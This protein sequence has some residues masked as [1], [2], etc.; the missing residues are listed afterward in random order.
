MSEQMQ[1]TPEQRIAIDAPEGPV[2]VIAG[3]GSGKTAVMA[4]RIATLIEHGR[5]PDEIVGLTFSNKAAENLRRRVADE[6][7]GG[8]D[9]LVTTYH[10]FG[11]SIVSEFAEDLGF[12][13]VPRLI[14]RASAFQLLYGAL[15]HVVFERR[16]IGRVAHLAAAALRLASQCSD[17]LVPVSRVI[18]DCDSMVDDIE[19]LEQVRNAARG[20]RDLARLVEIYRQVKTDRGFIDFGDQIALAVEALR[21]NGLRANAMRERH[22]VVLLD[23]YQDT[24]FAQRRLLQLIYPPGSPITVVG[25]DMQAIYAFRGSHLRNLFDFASHF[26]TDAHEGKPGAV[27]EAALTTNF[28]SGPQIVAVA[29]AVHATVGTAKDKAL[30]ARENA[31]A[32]VVEA[33]LCADELAEATRVASWISDRGAPWDE[34]IVLGRK[35]KIFPLIADALAARGIPVEILGIGGL[36][37]RPE[38]VDLLAWLEVLALE[39]ANVASLR[40]LRSPLRNI[41]MH[42]LAALAAHA[43][44]LARLRAPDDAHPNVQL[45][46]ALESVDSVPGLSAEA[47]QRVKTLLADRAALTHRLDDLRLPDL[48]EAIIQVERLRDRVDAVGTENLLRFLDVAERFVPLDGAATV[49]SFLDYLHLVMDGE[50]E[51]AEAVASATAAVRIMTIHQAKGLEFDNVVIAGLAGSKKSS[52]IFPD[53][54][55]SE[56]GATQMEVLPLWLRE[57]NDGITGPPRTKAQMEAQKRHADAMRA[58]EERRLLYVAVTRAKTRLLASAAH[59][60]SGPADPQGPSAFY[61]LIAAQT[62]HVVEHLPRAAP[63]TQNPTVE[64]RRRLADAQRRQSLEAPIASGAS[65]RRSKRVSTAQGSMLDANAELGSVELAV[66]TVPNELSVSDLAT[67]ARCPKQFEWR[68]ITPLPTRRSSAADVGTNVH[69]RIAVIAAAGRPLDVDDGAPTERPGPHTDASRY[70]EGLAV[71]SEHVERTASHRT[72]REA[73]E[74]ADALVAVFQG[75]RWAGHTATAVEVPFAVAIGGTLLRGRVDAR[76]DIGGTVHI[77]DFKTGREPD[78]SDAGRDVQLDAYGLVASEQWGVDSTS[79]ETSY[80]YIQHSGTH[81]VTTTWSAEH[82]ADTRTRLE[83]IDRRLRQGHFDA[84]PGP[85]C[86]ACDF[87]TMCPSASTRQQ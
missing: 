70:V 30:I 19:I 9:V 77:V 38:I 86:A 23:E 74:A 80:V 46:R 29:N 17:H 36:L 45:L 50:D 75:S 60:Y 58:D 8:I 53:E 33:V 28:R 18:E 15:D 10:G 21:L 7:G 2:R 63:T 5:R 47:W 69:E 62:D 32:A 87:A 4:Q 39:D 72:Y 85:W 31:P 56:N 24:N 49:L 51:P 73:Q 83:A 81:D 40:L 34:T 59:W 35:R 48:V 66:T 25:D 42:D 37:T 1:P 76:Y 44:T 20:R 65:K 68:V 79:L 71:R 3:A 52:S 57:D 78:D 82:A 67:F 61:E 6:V 43:R 11:A 27:T 14:D 54:R 64:R 55:I 16:K 41:G 12:D 13:H 84:A 26:G 22:P